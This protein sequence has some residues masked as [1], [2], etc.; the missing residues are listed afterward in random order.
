MPQ[1][2][3]KKKGKKTLTGRWSHAENERFLNGL[4]KFGKNWV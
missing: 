4:E 1:E 3:T 2:K